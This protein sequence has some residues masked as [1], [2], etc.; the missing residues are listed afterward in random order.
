MRLR[1]APAALAIFVLGCGPQASADVTAVPA[2]APPATNGDDAGATD[3]GGSPS[4]GAL[5][6][7]SGPETDPLF[8]LPTGAQQL[9]IL[10]ARNHRD[11]VAN[12]FCATPLPSVASVL[13]LERV[14]KLD[15]K[16]GATSNGQGGN[17]AFALL[18]QSSSLATRTTTPINPRAFV[19]TAP[20]STSGVLV[21]T[22]QP[23]VPN[24]QFVVLAFVRGEQFVELA[25]RDATS[26]GDNTLRFYLF[27]FK[28]ACNAAPQ[29]CNWGDLFTPAVESAFTEY[30]LYEDVDI[31]NRTLDCTGCHQPGGTG[32]AKHL[33]MRELQ[34]NWKHWMFGPSDANLRVPEKAFQAAHAP[35]ED[36]GGIPAALLSKASPAELQGLIENN[37]GYNDQPF[38]F[39]SLKI[40]SEIIASNPSATPSVNDPPNSSAT[41]QNLFDQAKIG[42]GLTPPYVDF[43]AVDSA[44]KLPAA[45]AAYRSV[46]AGA[47]PRAQLPDISDIFLDSGLPFL[48]FVPS[49]GFT[50]RQILVE[51]CHQCHNA[52]VDPS[53]SRSHFNVETLD[54]LSR[55]EKDLAIQRI[56]L[57][58]SD[59]HHMPPHRF[60][61]LGPADIEAVTQELMK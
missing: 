24:P 4:D 29:G 18:S 22:P 53:I 12:A 34:Y 58:G 37:Y 21:R 11:P 57:P 52:R 60:R 30:T 59:A 54:T 7:G 56:H 28:Q 43:L 16:A 25:A 51:A 36:Y 17:P 19:F 13:D 10:C 49:P 35:S 8:G 15:F 32:A 14:L 55:G 41:W 38:Q 33:L 48:M 47:T 5:G 42:Q 45:T 1:N 44:T 26:S 31:T 3:A 61:D 9:A 40:N 27:R 50:G 6:P 20:A 2:E 46:M 23:F 39:D